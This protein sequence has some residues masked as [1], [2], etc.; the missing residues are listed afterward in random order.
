MWTT[1]GDCPKVIQRGWSQ[2]L[3]GDPMRQVNM[4]IKAT[5]SVLRDW[6]KGVFHY[7]HTEINLIRSKLDTLMRLPFDS[8]RFEYQKDLNK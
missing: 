5:E 8:N 7:R 2:P 1:H 6:H 3:T 4:K